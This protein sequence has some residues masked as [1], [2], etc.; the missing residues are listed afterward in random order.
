MPIGDVRQKSRGQKSVFVLGVY[1]SAVHARWIGPDGK[2]LIRAVGVATEPEI[3]W[4]GE[5][6]D[7]IIAGIQIPAASGH[8]KPALPGS[9]GPSG[10]SLNERFLRPLGLSRED[11]WLS[12]LLPRSRM[13]GSQADALARAYLPNVEKF[14]LPNF[15]WP[16]VPNELASSERRAEILG[17]I[18]EAQ[19]DVLVTLGDQPLKWFANQLD[20]RA[21]KRL[22]S[23][24]TDNQRYGDLHEIEL[25]GRTMKLLPLVHPRQASA[26]GRS[27]VAW[28]A[29]HD[30]WILNRAP[31]LLASS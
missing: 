17:E 14:G 9:N 24:G 2:E 4:T 29:L 6:A 31:E 12:D 15:L 5:G 19:P 13:N 28:K 1:A 7:E 21:H 26:L 20:P 30:W 25:G 8:L 16:T 22:S 11:V 10:I 23:F 27:S 18:E 3:F